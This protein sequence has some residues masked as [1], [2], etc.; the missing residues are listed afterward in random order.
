MLRKLN[1]P[2]R[3]PEFHL[4]LNLTP[5]AS[6]VYVKLQSKRRYKLNAADVTC[7]VC[8]EQGVGNASR[9]A[10]PKDLLDTCTNDAMNRTA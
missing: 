3:G 7:H 8:G 10:F 5:A 6:N 4:S 9:G 2:I 1:G